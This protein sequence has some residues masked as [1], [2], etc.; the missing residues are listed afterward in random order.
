MKY[1]LLTM[2]LMAPLLLAGASASGQPFVRMVSSPADGSWYPLGAKIME[3]LGTEVPGIATSNGPGGGVS[4]VQD[5][6][7][8]AAE[9]GWSHA[10]TAYNGMHGEG[11]FDKPQENIRYFATLYPGALQT[12]VP[13]DSDITSYADLKDKNLS[14]GKAKWSGFAATESLLKYYGFTIEE[15]KK[16]GGTI[17]NVSYGDSVALM[18]NGHIDAVMALTSVPQASL[19]ELNYK[20]GIRLLGV[21]PDILEKFL[22]DNPGYIRHDIPKTAYEN[23]AADVPTLGVVTVLVVHKDLPEDVAYNMA[24][25]LWD[26]HGEFAK[27][28]DVWNTVSLE[29]ALLGAPIPVHPGAMR[30]YEEQGVQKK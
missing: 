26:N 22:A 7:K 30:Y 2:G 18:K 14:P 19:I 15:V 5:V 11:K 1:F 12:A 25:A 28:K 29:N 9:I 4:T 21:E 8:G 24:K 16:N 23:M 3:V 27:V 20:P 10:H 13:R 6:N 17:H